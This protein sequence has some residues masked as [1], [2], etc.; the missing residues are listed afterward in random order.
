MSKPAVPLRT[1]KRSRRR[2]K[3]LTAVE[4]QQL[5]AFDQALQREAWTESRRQ[6]SQAR[7]VAT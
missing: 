5:A 7:A 4:R 6:M 1:W 2:D 3:R